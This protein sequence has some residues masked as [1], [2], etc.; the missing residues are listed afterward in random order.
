V[1]PVRRLL[2]PRRALSLGLIAAALDVTIDS[3]YAIPDEEES[4]PPPRSG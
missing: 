4:P 2:S 1:T 3:L